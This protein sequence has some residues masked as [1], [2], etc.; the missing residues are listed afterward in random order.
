MHVTAQSGPPRAMSFASSY[1]LPAELTRRGARSGRS[2]NCLRTRGQL[3]KWTS[4]QRRNTK[5][6]L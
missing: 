4:S 2:D 1:D 3:R 6:G 5:A